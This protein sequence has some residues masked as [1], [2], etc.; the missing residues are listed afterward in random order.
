M[1]CYMAYKVLVFKY[2]PTTLLV[3]VCFQKKGNAVP[4]I[5]CI[6]TFH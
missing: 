3:F 4:T 5:V 2:D 6:L 1:S